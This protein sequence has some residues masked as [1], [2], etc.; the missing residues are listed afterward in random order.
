MSTPRTAYRTLP[1]DERQE[2]RLPALL[3]E[4]LVQAAARTG[5]TVAEYITDALA[6]RVSR[7]LA[8]ATEWSLTVPEQRALLEALA[9]AAAPSARARKAAARAAALFG[10]LKTRRRAR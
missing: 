2:F 9:G 7:D 6:E 8:T 1:A 4:H 10:P 3:K 5:E